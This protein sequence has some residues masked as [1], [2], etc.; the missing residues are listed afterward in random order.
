MSQPLILTSFDRMRF[1]VIDDDRALV[2]LVEA[3]LLMAAVGG[4]VKTTS[5]LAAINIL[6]D[7][8]KKVDC[9]ICD[10]GMPMMN[11]LQFL[12]EIR[13][14][15]HAHIPRDMCFVMLTAQGAEEVVR[16]ALALDVHGYVRK[17]VSKDSLVK[18]IHRAFN[19]TIAL[20]PPEDYAAVEVPET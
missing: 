19:R 20:K 16:A 18:A 12:R 9:I 3:M 5:C 15:R 17:P 13:A 10:Q 2:E 4:V 14:G 11:G 6:A 8:S 7:R 1:M